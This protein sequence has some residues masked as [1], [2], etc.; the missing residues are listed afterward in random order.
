MK[1]LRIFYGFNT[2]LNSTK[3]ETIVEEILGKIKYNWTLIKNKIKSKEK[4]Q[5]F[6]SK[7]KK[8]NFK[9]HSTFKKLKN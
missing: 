5:S 1:I 3:T 4:K 6:F 8:S 7:K 9:I 2:Y